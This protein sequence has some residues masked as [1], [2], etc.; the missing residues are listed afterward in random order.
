M[1]GPGAG[2][3]SFGRM[4]SEGLQ[5]LDTQL[6]TSQADLQHLA[7][8]E[9]QNLHEVMIRLEESRIALQLALQVRNRVLEAYQDV[10]KMQ[11]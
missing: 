9:A 11:V 1:A 6:K 5:A 3:L 8:G 7:L 4:V 2:S 10:M